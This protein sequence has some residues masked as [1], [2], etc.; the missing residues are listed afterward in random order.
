M[1]TFAIIGL[2]SRGRKTYLKELVK[3]PER[4]KIVAIADPDEEKLKD[5][6]EILG[7]SPEYCFS[8][9]EALLEQPK[10]ADAVLIC[11]HEQQHVPQAIPAIK[12]GYH[13]LVEKPIAPD[14]E[15]CRELLAVAREYDR[16][17]VV[18]H[19]LRYSYFYRKIKE[20]LDSGD[21]GELKNLQASEEVA[22]WHYA[23]SFVRGN[24]RN[25]N[26]TSPMFLAKCCHDMDILVWLTGQKCRKV[27][28]FG[29]L[30]H[31]REECAPEGAAR[32]CLDGCKAKDQCPFDAEKIYI[33]NKTGVLHTKG[34]ATA[35]LAVEMTE[36]NVREALKKGPYGRCVYYCDN[37]VVDH[38]VVN[39]E[40]EN[41][42]TVNFSMCGFCGHGRRYMNIMGTRGSMIADMQ[43]EQLIISV[44]GQETK[45]IDFAD[46]KNKQGGHGGGDPVLVREFLDYLS[47]EEPKGIT[48][49]ED[50]MESH[51][52][53]MAAEE[54]RLRGGESI[55][56]AKFRMS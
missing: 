3:M 27:S 45:V 38:Q 29:S 33:T 47:G 49:L 25:S 21:L 34:W 10:L 16:K 17:V 36:E 19:V 22:Y 55:E 35:M 40:M 13:V 54:S 7:L 23:H 12:K 4:A 6:A 31:Y 32:R 20:I 39:L 15:S 56:L 18:C 5:A 37:N 44:F 52:I 46:E 1:L 53:A 14:V 2:G 51:F 26:V 41:G 24:W 28:S 30:D 42:L 48:V 50:S 8:S 9:A 43:K 11:T